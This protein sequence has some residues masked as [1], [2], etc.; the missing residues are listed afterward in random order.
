MDIY[1]LVAG[2]T[3]D[4]TIEPA[5]RQAK[6]VVVVLNKEFLGKPYPM[7]ELSWLLEEGDRARIVPVLLDG[8]S[9]G[10]LKDCTPDSLKDLAEDK[11]WFKGQ[12]DQQQW[13]NDIQVIAKLGNIS[14][15]D[16]YAFG[17]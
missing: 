3:A 17:R 7:K 13:A 16:D 15:E 14:Q 6:A 12:Q 11:Q 5:L 4:Q 1:D 2:Q 8:L 9:R 10:A